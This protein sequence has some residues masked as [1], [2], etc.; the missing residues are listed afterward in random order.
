MP[1]L[2]DR[3]RLARPVDAVTSQ[4]PTG[5]N[6]LA[7]RDLVVSY[8][9]VRVL[10]GVSIEVPRG[11]RVALLG[12]NGAGKST[13]LKAVSGLLKRDAGTN[14]SV[15]FDGDDITSLPAEARV[16]MGMVHIGGGRATFP[17]L[18]VE[19][20]LKIGAYPFLGDAG[21]VA[22]RMAEV[23]D[24]FPNLGTR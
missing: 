17:S 20:N 19:E 13:L 12:T 24:L 9:S 5:E 21:L 16:A 2:E 15:W 7:V 11:S 4:A 23:L 8:G 3:R 1:M 14:G 22:Q 6:L 18:S 10:F